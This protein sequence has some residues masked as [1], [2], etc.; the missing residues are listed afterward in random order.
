MGALLLMA[1]Q[2]KEKQLIIQSLLEDQKKR[3][4]GAL[5]LTSNRKKVKIPYSDI[6]FIESLSDYIKV[7]TLEE[8]VVSKEKISHLYNRLPD[9]FLRI[10]RSFIVNKEK[11]KSFSYNEVLVGNTNLNIGRSY[12]QAV[13]EELKMEN[14]KSQ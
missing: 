11:I 9:S 14:N 5:E 13:K 4:Q 1:R 2:V 7:N 12:R 3:E 6:I 10:H 8:G